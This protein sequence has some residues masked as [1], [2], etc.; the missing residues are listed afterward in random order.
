MDI[1]AERGAEVLAAARELWDSQITE[2]FGARARTFCDAL[3]FSS[4]FS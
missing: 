3:S 2:A 4:R 1:N